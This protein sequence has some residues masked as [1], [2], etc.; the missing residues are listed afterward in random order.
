MSIGTRL[1]PESR[2]CTVGTGDTGGGGGGG[3]SNTGTGGTPTSVGGYGG[4]AGDGWCSAGL[5]FRHCP[6]CV[7]DLTPAR[8]PA[9]APHKSLRVGWGLRS[10]ELELES[11]GDA[12]KSSD[13][14]LDG[15]LHVG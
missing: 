1:P 9:P 5:N 4:V 10:A 2:E 6:A 7:V 15:G 3:G 8:D 12:K 11:R 13:P 14:L